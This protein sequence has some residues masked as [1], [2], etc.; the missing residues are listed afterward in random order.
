MI[1]LPRRSVTRFFIPLIDVLTLL[2]CI[3]LLMPLVSTGEG[4]AGEGQGKRE[5][6]LALEEEVR[7]LRE[8]IQSRPGEMRQE[9]EQIRKEKIDALEKRL[10]VRVLEIDGAT[11]KLYYREPAG[12]VELR[13]EA[14]ARAL[15]ARDRARSQRELYYVVLYPRDARSNHPEG[16]ERRRYEN[17]LK[18]VAHEF[19]V[20]ARPLGEGGMP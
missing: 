8:A 1:T 4:E 19:D 13:S 17:W 15:A 9:L 6:N 18:G 3:F 12:R 14:D 16:G 20:P 11:G 7:N 10:A 5:Q 2:F